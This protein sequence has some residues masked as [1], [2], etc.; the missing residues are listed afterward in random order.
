MFL[1]HRAEEMIVQSCYWNRKKKL[2]NLLFHPFFTET[3]DCILSTGVKRRVW[4]RDSKYRQE[5]YLTV[6]KK[7]AEHLRVIVT[8]RL[9]GAVGGAITRENFSFILQQT[10]LSL[11]AALRPHS[12]F[13]WNA[14]RVIERVREPRGRVQA[15][16]ASQRGRVLRERIFNV[17][18]RKQK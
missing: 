4:L 8:R 9:M 14:R 11:H 3:N 5:F 12:S 18:Q 16:R 2:T 6:W 10:L 13:R 17:T 7:I 1:A 15:R